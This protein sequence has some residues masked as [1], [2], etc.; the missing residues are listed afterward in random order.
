MVLPTTNPWDLVDFNAATFSEFESVTPEELIIVPE[1]STYFGLNPGRTAMEVRSSDGV[2]ASI[3]PMVGIPARFTLQLVLRCPQLPHNL[4]DLERR[5]FAITVADDAGRGFSLYLA[6]T[7]VGLSRVGNFGAAT[8]LP[9]TSDVTAAVSEHYFTLRIAVDGTLGRALVFVGEG[10]TDAPP[11]RLYIPV[12]Q[13]PGTVS[14]DIFKIEARGLANEPVHVELLQIR[15][16]GQLVV[17]NYP[18]IADAG[19][20]RAASV[21]NAIRFDGRASYDVEGSPIT[22]LWRCIDAPY[23]SHYA[24]EVSN[25]VTEDDGD[26]DGVTPLIAVDVLAIP[27]WLDVGDV[28]RLGG[29]VYEVSA[30]YRGEGLIEVTSDGVP[31]NFEGPIRLIRQSILLDS[32]SPTPVALPDIAGLYRFRLTVSDGDNDSEP[33]EVLA[34]IAPLQTPIGIEPDVSPIWKAIGDEWQLIDGRHVFEQAWIGTAQILAG[35]LLE[36]WQ[37]H[38]NTSIR[39]AQQLFQRKWIGYRTVLSEPAPDDALISPRHGAFAAAYRFAESAPVLGGKEL[40]IEVLEPAGTY[41]SVAISFP[42]TD[43]NQYTLREIIAT[44][45]ERLADL[46][47][48]SIWAEGRCTRDVGEDLRFEGVGSTLDLAPTASTLELASGLW[49]SW[50]NAGDVLCIAGGRYVATEPTIFG[51]GAGIL[52]GGLT[53]APFTYY[54]LARLI[55]QGSAP[56]RL[57]GE[58]AGTLGL[59]AGRLNQVGGLTGYRITD[60]M[61]Y[62][63]GVDLV[64]AAVARGDLL[65]VNNGES[66]AIDR[67]LSDPRDP[68]PNQR[69]LLFEGTPEDT[70]SSWSIPSVIRSAE[71]DYEREGAY[72]GDLAKTEIY[73]PS[74]GHVVTTNSVVVAQ[75]GTQL[76]VALGHE[77]LAGILAGKEVRFMGIKRRKGVPIPDDAVSIPMLQEL[78]PA[79]LEPELFREHLDFIIEPFYRDEGGRPVPMLQFHDEVWITP[80]K[81]PPDV[82]WAE[83]TLFSNEKNVEGLFGRLVGFMRDDAASFP[84]DFRYISGVAGLLYAQQRGPNLFSMAVG[85]QILLGQPFAEVAGYI[86]EIRSDYS[87]TH[88]R[89]LLRDDDGTVP[90]Q[91]ETVR[92]YYYQK[93]PNELTLQ[94]G[95]AENPETGALWAKGDKVPQFSPLGAG[96]HIDDLYTDPNWWKP[97]VGSNIMYEPEKFHSFVIRYNVTVANLANISL[98][99]GLMQRIEP[100][101]TK[102]LLIGAHVH[103]DDLDVADTIEPTVILDP[104]EGLLRTYRAYRWD[105][106]RG[107]GSI[108]H[109]F[110]DG[111]TRFDAHVDTP[112]DL[113]DFVITVSWPGGVLSFPTEWPFS[114]DVQVRDVDGAE[115]GIV[116]SLFSLTDGMDLAAGTYLTTIATKT[117]P[118]LPPL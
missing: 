3:Q 20:D 59:P 63:E 103:Q 11:L 2:I 10:Q 50:A 107:D 33:S 16:A 58:A 34:N 116:G 94:S 104:H 6:K 91:S 100:T 96:V 84:K 102:G 92:A 9:D 38:Y 54:R 95:L 32:L 66:F 74:S 118:V 87:P 109:S 48:S 70:T 65:V 30:V 31:D 79:A 83:T 98:L 8:A 90:T 110:D 40:T 42:L 4:G 115:T 105:D 25:A 78:I 60:R 81:E 15:L 67:L 64:R 80:D 112:L 57:T 69:I 85:A 77:A 93:D 43:G 19:T 18:P 71:V 36:A 21:G 108:A 17:A 61:F 56:F 99:G 45:N 37:V 82:L 55:L 106:Y 23:G 68:H 44:I 41:R 1:G 46:G 86:E 76:A 47:I 97:Y 7:G 111:V 12:E 72:P 101:Y 13:T 52:P 39:D 22:Y 113:I 51:A 35:K 88:G 75:K 73:T 28:V 49:P 5:R 14:N 29:G 89:L 24:E 27:E 62:V 114:L 117:G 26:A 53:D